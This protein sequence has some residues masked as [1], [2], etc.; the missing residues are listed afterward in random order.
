MTSNIQ[1]SSDL[2]FVFGP[3]RLFPAQRVL[4][5]GGEPVALGSRARE[6][7]IALVENAGK[8]VK[9]NELCGRAW[10]DTVVE[11]GTLRVHIAALR[12]AL[13]DRPSGG[14]RYVE[15]VTGHGYRFVAPVTR[16]DGGPSH[17]WETALPAEPINNLPPC[18]SRV[19]G[20]EHAVTT[21]TQRLG[22]RRFMTVV[23]P[24]GIGKTTVAVSAANAL[25]TSYA[26]G[27]CFVD[28]GSVSDPAVI[29]VTVA[30]A[31]GLP[32]VVADPA[33]GIVA[34]LKDKQMLI[35]LD[36]CEHLVDGAAA[37]AERLLGGA[38]GVHIL[39]TSRETLRAKGEW[40]LRLGPLELP[41]P[42]ATVTAKAALAF[43][44]IQ[45]FAE[46]VAASLESFAL[47]DAEVPIVAEICRRV[48]GLPLA[49]EL[50]AA[51]VAQ[52]G[53][54]ELAARLDDRL[55]VLTGGRR[56]ALKRHQ[57]L[58][59]T[60]DWSY[61]LLSP[62]EQRV[63]RR[64][65]VFAGPFDVASACVVAA[66]ADGDPA[67]VLEALTH[68]AA[69]S[70]IG[71]HTGEQQ[72]LYRLL[73]TSRAYAL[74]KLTAGE[75]SAQIRRRHAEL[76]CT[77]GESAPARGLQPANDWLSGNGHKVDDVRTALDWCF[78]TQGDALLGV[79][80][81]AMSAPFWFNL[82]LLNEY[83]ERLSL[84]LK[85]LPNLA[86]ADG[87]L[88]N[89]ELANPE[90]EIQLKAAFGDTLVYT[91][92]ASAD[93]ATA[94]TSAL[95][96]AERL[97]LFLYRKRALWGLWVDRIM[98][99]DYLPA[100]ALA[101]R[102]RL[103]ANSGPTVGVVADRMMALSHH[104][105]G[106][107]TVAR[108]YA[109]QALKWPVGPGFP[110]SDPAVQFVR[111]TVDHRVAAHAV[112]AHVLWIQGFADQALNASRDS[113]RCAL[114]LNHPLSL[115]YGLTCVGGVTLWRGDLDEAQRQVAMLLEHSG[116]NGLSYWQ[117]WGRCIEL[118]V[119]WRQKGPDKES[120]LTL[121]RNPLCTPLHV[122]ALGALI[123]DSVG[124]LALERARGGL[125]GWCAPELLRA[126]GEA[127]LT[128]SR[129]NAVQAE[130]HFHESLELARRQGALSWE[131]RAAMSLAR[132]W[133]SQGNAL[134]AYH[135]LAPVQARFTEGFD[136]VDL[137][138]ASALLAD[139]AASKR[140]FR[141]A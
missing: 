54:R 40:V 30:A 61:E 68:L 79:T 41:P 111:G 122:E 60:L 17:A 22:E 83:R 37:L 113:V 72:V 58:R 32:M 8:L 29:P 11:E 94:F 28:L 56:T 86:S 114:A 59:A 51:R 102:F 52:L 100:M 88:S 91:Q 36:N 116:P 63:L 101:E 131:L 112:L 69:K 132:L 53:I 80:L 65:A 87:A 13:G 98:A 70:L 48:D 107:L 55:R 89:S 3:F 139:L 75:E 103:V 4:M 77:W 127:L 105:C 44:A 16:Y 99:A 49:I 92:G 21:L 138:A 140:R 35:V 126:E 42:S 9:K 27:V 96:L 57:T 18:L 109:E 24:G 90:L 23:G 39:A 66:E 104:L 73:E 110:A 85:V 71:V 38:E 137:L 130:K 141:R 84:A 136:T 67:D 95:G 19:I 117:F 15:N 115:C 118:A 119:A 97:D 93:A 81:T 108:H 106:N 20:R 135:L 12:R 7:L 120:R 46:R 133:Q 10:P 34:C 1:T 62:F 33:P 82:C 124:R 129:T 43:P 76:C 78:S 134:E 47:T 26:H 45:L 50:A 64:L 6:I 5:C 121:L 128:S 123:E 2:A 25:R 74:E 125:A 14:N 31:L